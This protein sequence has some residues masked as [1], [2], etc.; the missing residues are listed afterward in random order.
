M[1]KVKIA[2]LP[3][4][5]NLVEQPVNSELTSLNNYLVYS[6][7]IGGEIVDEFNVRSF[8]D[9]P[10]NS[11]IANNFILYLENNATQTEINEIVYDNKK[12]ADIFNDFYNKT[13]RDSTQP[14]VTLIQS[15]ITNTSA[16]TYTSNTFVFSPS[17]GFVRSGDMITEL[18]ESN[19]SPSMYISVFIP[20]K[21][22]YIEATFDKYTKDC[23]DGAKTL[24]TTTVNRL[25]VG[26]QEIKEQNIVVVENVPNRLA[27]CFVS[28]NK[29]DSE[30]EFWGAQEGTFAKTATKVILT[31]GPGGSLTFGGS[32]TGT[33]GNNVN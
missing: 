3:E 22:D 19:N 27:Q 24:K 28:L 4:F 1:Q 6:S 21:Y 11:E 12:L 8:L 30:F 15:A 16:V 9:N 23:I 26:G 13:V 31:P 20:K 5:E 7:S 33:N 14:D 29:N 32:S 2:L 10:D 17:S 25:V 18:T